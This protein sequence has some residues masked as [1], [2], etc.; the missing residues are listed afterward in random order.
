MIKFQ[1]KCYKIFLKTV[2]SV[3]ITARIRITIFQALVAWELFTKGYIQGHKNEYV[4]KI[5]Y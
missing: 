2:W 1:H 3:V 5:S 4:I